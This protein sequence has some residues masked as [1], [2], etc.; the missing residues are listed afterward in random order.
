MLGKNR[1]IKRFDILLNVKI[2]PNNEAT[3]YL[4]GVTGN[5]SHEGLSFESKS[6]APE[7][8]EPLDLKIQHPIKNTF[9]SSFS[10]IVWKKDLNGICLTGVKFREINEE[11]KNEIL[12]VAYEIKREMGGH[13]G[14]LSLDKIKANV[15][16]IKSIFRRA[17]LYLLSV[18]VIAIILV[19]LSTNANLNKSSQLSVKAPTKEALQLPPFRN[20]AISRALREMSEQTLQLSTYHN[21]T[22]TEDKDKLAP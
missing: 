19:G 18:I 6:F 9:I 16:A 12:D 20:E 5:F 4:W 15:K 17:W 11:A 21:E 22:I 13:T 10:D 2:R 1:K 3:G 7:P 8:K 14:E